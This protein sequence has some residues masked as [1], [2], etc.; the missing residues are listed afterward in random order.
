[1]EASLCGPGWPL[2]PWGGVHSMGTAIRGQA[3]ESWKGSQ[4]QLPHLTQDL[5]FYH[6][7]KICAIHCQ[8][9]RPEEGE[10]TDSLGIPLPFCIQ[11]YATGICIS[12]S[13]QFTVYREHCHSLQSK[14]LKARRDALYYKNRRKT[15]LSFISAFPKASFQVLLCVWKD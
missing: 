3:V 6:G 4:S 13:L 1:M 7:S 2:P 15:A 5:H 8:L 11:S 12:F 10:R 9:A 14:L